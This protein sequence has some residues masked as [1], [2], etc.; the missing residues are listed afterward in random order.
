M[1]KEPSGEEIKFKQLNPPIVERR[2]TVIERAQWQVNEKIQ[3][4]EGQ[5]RDYE[6]LN[7]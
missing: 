7:Y 3:Y 4:L 2:R 6:K 1:N 5:L